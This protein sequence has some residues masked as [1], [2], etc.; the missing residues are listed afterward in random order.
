[1]TMLNNVFDVK[2]NIHTNPSHLDKVI[3]LLFPLNL[4]L[5]YIGT[6]GLLSDR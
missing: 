4:D 3:Q 2:R 1:M 5:E 6:R